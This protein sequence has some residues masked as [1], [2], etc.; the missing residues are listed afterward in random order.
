MAW[1]DYAND[2]EGKS[3][4][5]S[6]KEIIMRMAATIRVL[7][8]AKLDGN[9]TLAINC[10]RSLYLD[11]CGL[12]REEE[13]EIGKEIMVLKKRSNPPDENSVGMQLSQGAILYKIDEI[14]ER[15]RILAHQHGLGVSEREDLSGL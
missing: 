13:R 4:W 7:N 3:E 15:L 6:N 12:L 14:D 11:F 10:L 5:N 9:T 8:Q 2:D 1:K